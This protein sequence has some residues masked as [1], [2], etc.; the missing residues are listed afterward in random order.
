MCSSIELRDQQDGR[1][2]DWLERQVRRAPHPRRAWATPSPL[3]G[4]CEAGAGKVTGAGKPVAEGSWRVGP[5]GG[6]RRRSTQYF[7]CVCFCHTLSHLRIPGIRAP[8]VGLFLHPGDESGL[9]ASEP[10]GR[11]T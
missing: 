11:R 6:P 8:Q 1:G 10:W 2:T 5:R 7:T 3:L 4:G 9:G